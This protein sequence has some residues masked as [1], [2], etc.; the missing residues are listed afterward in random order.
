MIK[1]D[2]NSGVSRDTQRPKK[3]RG[4]DKKSHRVS[5]SVLSEYSEDRITKLC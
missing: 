3:L 5:G 4:A 2:F 1:N